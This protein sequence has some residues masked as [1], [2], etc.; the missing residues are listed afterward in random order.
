MRIVSG[1]PLV[2][3]VMLELRMSLA[4]SCGKCLCFGSLWAW[5][6]IGM[7][8]M[9]HDDGGYRVLTQKAPNRLEIGSKR[10]AV[11]GKKRL[12]RQAEPV[13]DRQADAAVSNV[14]S[15]D[16]SGRRHGASVRRSRNNR[17]LGER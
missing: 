14:Q 11:D 8:W 17:M 13:R 2:E 16:A 3:Q 1:Q 7:E 5:A 4:Q 10:G 15:E 12:R 9:A 6:A